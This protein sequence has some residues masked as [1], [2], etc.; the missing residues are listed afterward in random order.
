[1]HAAAAFR[2][3]KPRF[4]VGTVGSSRRDGWNHTKMPVLCFTGFRGIG[5]DAQDSRPGIFSAVPA[6]LVLVA[7][8]TQD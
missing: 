3:E 6:G 2:Q 1:V 5:E 8:Y 7:M 4:N